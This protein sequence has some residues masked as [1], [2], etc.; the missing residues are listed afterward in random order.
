MLAVTKD[1]TRVYTANISANTASIIDVGSGATATA[2]KTIPVVSA[3]EGIALSPDEREVWVGSAQNGGISIIDTQSESVVA[4]ISPGT[5]AY[6][7]FFTPD[8]RN[9]VVPRPGLLAIYDAVT[10]VE[11]RTIPLSGSP[12][13]VVIADDN[14]TAYVAMGGPNRVLKVDLLSGAVL[15]TVNVAPTPDGLAL[16]GNPPPD[17]PWKKR[18]A[19]RA[20]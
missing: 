17:P 16:A 19:V 18:R 12:F 3:S 4:T 7:L 11:L 9:V 2:R 8:G 10:R 20:N 5:F 14:R 6:R 13:S 1:G 15:G